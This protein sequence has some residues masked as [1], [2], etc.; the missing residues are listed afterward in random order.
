MRPSTVYTTCMYEY[1]IKHWISF[2]NCWTSLHNIVNFTCH[3][4]NEVAIRKFIIFTLK[5]QFVFDHY[6]F[7]L[8]WILAIWLTSMCLFTSTLHHIS[9]HVLYVPDRVLYIPTRVL[10]IPAH[11]LYVPTRVLYVPHMYYSFPHMSY[12][13]PP[14]RYYLYGS[15]TC[16]IRSHTCIIGLYVNSTQHAE[17]A[18]LDCL[19]SFL[20]AA[21]AG[22][23]ADILLM[24]SA[25]FDYMVCES[26]ALPVIIIRGSTVFGDAVRAALPS[27][28]KTDNQ[29]LSCHIFD[30]FSAGLNWYT[31]LS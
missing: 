16:I 17:S 24:F 28:K 26:A 20:S 9:T 29:D 5:L 19:L 15:R 22:E 6:G 10:Y 27:L 12:M 25:I 31:V 2:S 3:P 13:F 21:D 30:P 8:V 11:V 23:K 4:L 7:C 1:R 14:W 18:C